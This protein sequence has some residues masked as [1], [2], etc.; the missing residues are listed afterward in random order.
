MTY[1]CTPRCGNLGAGREKETSL[2]RKQS[3]RGLYVALATPFGADDAPD[4]ALLAARARELLAQGCDGIALFGT[5]GEGPALPVA[6]R[7]A[8]LEA[9]LGASI[10]AARL[11]VSA[12][13]TAPADAL[14]LTRHAQASGVRDLLLTPAFFHKAVDDDGL[15][16]F[17]ARLIERAGGAPLRLILYHIPSVTGIGLS[18]DLIGRLAAAF[19]EVVIGVKDSGFDWALTRSLLERFPELEILTGEESHLPQALALGGAGTICGM[20]NFI[21]PLLRR[22]IDTDDP[23]ER[24]SLLDLLVAI[25]QAIDRSGPFHQGLRAILADQTGE[26]AW[27]RC[28]PPASPLAEDRGRALLAEFHRLQGQALR[29]LGNPGSP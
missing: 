22:M 25:G 2:P 21:A 28:L 10:P 6:A 3:W 11:I 1:T 23:H 18:L 14:D 24:Q 29:L 8:G 17:Y 27:R 16:A 15:F 26:A 12:S 4:L 9:L 7:R 20:A 13:A 19:P 5:T